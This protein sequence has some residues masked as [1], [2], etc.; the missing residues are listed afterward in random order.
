MSGR[1]SLG[2]PPHPGWPAHPA[3]LVV[4]GAEVRLR[5]V[6]WRDASAW[7]RLRLRDRDYLERWEPTAA[8][9][10]EERNALWAWP[11]QC[12][13]LRSLARR[14]QCL[15]LAIVVDGAFAGQITVGNIVR[16]A[17]CSAWVGY[18]VTSE[19]AGRGIATAAVAMMTDHAFGAGRLHRLEAT[20]RPENTASV[21]V[22]TKVGFRKE[23]LFERYLHVT[24]EWRDHLVYA[25]TA[26]ESGPGLAERLVAEGRAARVH[27]G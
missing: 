7:S 24:G 5:P 17:L 14:G 19:L 23:G 6:R 4:A 1:D 9:P 25:V 10:W 3:P 20:V 2:E 16:A 11:P 22:L 13:S 26:E 27:S 8:G 18:W 12:A 21:R 15:P